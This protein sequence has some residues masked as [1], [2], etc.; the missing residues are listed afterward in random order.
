MKLDGEQREADEILEAFQYL[1][2]FGPEGWV[3]AK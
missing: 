3:P 2:G 1:I